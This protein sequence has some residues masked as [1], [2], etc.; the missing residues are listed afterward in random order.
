MLFRSTF[1][2]G[3]Y[4]F[5]EKRDDN[6]YPSYG[7]VAGSEKEDGTVT[8]KYSYVDTIM[9]AAKYAKVSPYHLASRLRQEMGTQGSPLAF[10]TYPGYE[11]Y[12]NFYNIG[13]YAHSGRPARENGAR[14]AMQSGSYLRPWTN[15]YKA[16][17]LYTSR[18][19]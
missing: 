12:F 3:E 1:L 2:A 16:C 9:Q 17:L 8:Y 10:G 18:C 4:S 7:I 11:G 5:T 14:Y 15:P 19:V 13:A 6:F